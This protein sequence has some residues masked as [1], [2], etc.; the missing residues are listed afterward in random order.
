MRWPVSE[1][2]VTVG[3]VA[4]DV[5]MCWRCD[6]EWFRAAHAVKA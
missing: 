3:A 1:V 6:P 5:L 2:I 4:K